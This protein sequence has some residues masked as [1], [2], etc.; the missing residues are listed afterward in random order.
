MELAEEARLT[1]GE[2]VDLMPEEKGGHAGLAEG[3]WITNRFFCFLVREVVVVGGM[4]ASRDGMWMGR[5]NSGL[6]ALLA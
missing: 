1:H 3:K 5:R 6:D 4:A 2:W